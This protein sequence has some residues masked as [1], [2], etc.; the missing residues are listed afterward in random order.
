[1]FGYRLR[2]PNSYKENFIFGTTE[3]FDG[4]LFSANVGFVT[5]MPY[6]YLNC[7]DYNSSTTIKRNITF[8]S[9]PFTHY[10]RYSDQDIEMV[11]RDSDD[12]FT[13]DISLT[14]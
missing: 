2:N 10:Q 8:Q 3:Y 11:F 1:M 13:S 4:K 7:I 12:T 6:N 5:D 14:V 9:D